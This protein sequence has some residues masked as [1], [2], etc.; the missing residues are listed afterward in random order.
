MVYA[1]NARFFGN[2]MNKV[3]KNAITMGIKNILDAEIIVLMANGTKK[4]EAIESVMS[5]VV[6][7]NIPVSALNTHKG[8]VYV[9]VDKEAASNL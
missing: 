1:Y 2:D 5:G 4:A 7:K 9:I 3:P 8:K 6:D